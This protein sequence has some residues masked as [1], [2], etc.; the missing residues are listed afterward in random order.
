LNEYVRFQMAN[1][2]TQ[3]GSNGPGVGADIAVGVAMAQQLVQ[4]GL[5]NPTGQPQSGAA[6]AAAASAG[7]DLLSPA[8]AAK[9][10]SVSE[11]DVIGAIESGDLKAKK[12]GTAYRISRGMIEEFLQK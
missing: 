2:L 1:S 7:F 5:L 3:P 8:D 12:I 9:L 10:L 4:Q 11:A 6:P